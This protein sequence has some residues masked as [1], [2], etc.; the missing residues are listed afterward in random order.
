MSKTVRV[1]F[2]GHRPRDMYGYDENRTENVMIKRWLL[3]TVLKI[4]KK[5]PN[6]HFIAGGALGTDTWGAEAVL[7]A[8]K[9]FPD[10]KLEIAVPC[11]NQESRWNHESKVRYHKILK[12]ADIVTYVSDKPY[13]YQSMQ[14]R[15]EY[16]VDN[17]H[18]IIAVWSGKQRGGTYNCLQYARQVGRTILILNPLNFTTQK[19]KRKKGGE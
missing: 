13:T 10:V 11:L 19:I 3:S 4:A 7:E 14:K 8:K 1:A 16:M 5:Y 9:H 18:V 2:T 6:A 12:Q 15:N 17:A